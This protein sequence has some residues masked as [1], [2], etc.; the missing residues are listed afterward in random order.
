MKQVTCLRIKK[1]SGWSRFSL[2]LGKPQVIFQC[3]PRPSHCSVELQKCLKPP[4]PQQRVVWC[5]ER[6][7]PREFSRQIP[8]G[9]AQFLVLEPRCWRPGGFC[10][11]LGCQRT[12]PGL[13][14]REMRVLAQWSPKPCQPEHSV[15]RA[16]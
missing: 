13:I 8:N 5:G 10:P 16:G 15:T 14:S 9:T 11:A 1:G 3:P 4:Q 2:L 7:R 6:S 12:I